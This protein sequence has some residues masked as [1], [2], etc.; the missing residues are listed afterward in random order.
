MHRIDPEACQSCGACASACP[1]GAI[2]M[3]SGKN[4]FAISDDCSD[5]CACESE[6]GYDAIKAD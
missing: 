5:C 3:P 1:A 6:C 4:Y 2:S